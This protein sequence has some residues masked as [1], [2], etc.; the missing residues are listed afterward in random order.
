MFINNENLAKVTKDLEFARAVLGFWKWQMQEDRICRHTLTTLADVCDLI[1]S[2]K[3][4]AV[5]EWMGQMYNSDP[6]LAPPVS[7][8]NED[9]RIKRARSSSPDRP[10]IKLE[11]SNNENYGPYMGGVLDDMTRRKSL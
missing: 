2:E 9:V 4:S 1:F 8:E 5:D 10:T 6:R 3:S 7:Y 11:P